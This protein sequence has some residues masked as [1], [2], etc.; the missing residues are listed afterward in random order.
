MSYL[1]HIQHENVTNIPYKVMDY[2]R[3]NYYTIWSS[4]INTTDIFQYLQ[5]FAKILVL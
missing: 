4:N 5:I 1:G 3:A 2:P